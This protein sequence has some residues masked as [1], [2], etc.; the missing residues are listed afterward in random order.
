MSHFRY[1]YM[2][3]TL[4]RHVGMKQTGNYFLISTFSLL[5]ASL[6]LSPTEANPLRAP[7][8]KDNKLFFYCTTQMTRVFHLIVENRHSMP[9]ASYDRISRLLISAEIDSQFKKYPSCFNKLERARVYLKHAGLDLDLP[10][11]TDHK[12]TSYRSN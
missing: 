10:E 7:D 11:K 12:Q 1:I 5:L 3:R 9:P 6:N 4:E 8:I 2:A